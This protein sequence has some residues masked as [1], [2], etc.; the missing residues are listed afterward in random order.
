MKLFL[1]VCLLA[2]AFGVVGC[3]SSRSSTSLR[4]EIPKDGVVLFEGSF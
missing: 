1:S 4:S 3:S 2:V